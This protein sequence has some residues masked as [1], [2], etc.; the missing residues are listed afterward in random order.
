MISPNEDVLKYGVQIQYPATNNEAEYEAILTSL[1]L[2]KA[3]GIKSLVIKSDSKPIVEKVN[4][5]YEAK[6]EQMQKYQ[7]LAIQMTGHFDEI[8]FIQVPKEENS[9]VDEVA[10]IASS[11]QQTQNEGLMIEIQALQVDSK[12]T[13][14]APILSFIQGEKLLED[15]DEARRTKVRSVRF[16]ILNGQ[17]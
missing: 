15:P 6:K 12:S 17:L 3:L 7:R 4:H 1:R 9:E 14:M 10:W 16:T 5:E 8:K 11:K 13:Q 2:A